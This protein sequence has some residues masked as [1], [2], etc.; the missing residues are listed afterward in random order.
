MTQQQALK[1]LMLSPLYFKLA[2][3]ERMQLIKE[4]CRLYVEVTKIPKNREGNNQ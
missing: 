2:T 3:V 1:I 4:Y